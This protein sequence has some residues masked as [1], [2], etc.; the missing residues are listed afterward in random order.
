MTLPEDDDSVFELFIDWLYR[1]RYEMTIPTAQGSGDIYMQPVRLFALADKYDVPSLKSLILSRTFLRIKKERVGKRRMPKL[2]TVAYAYEH[3]AENSPMRK[4][5][6]GSLTCR[7]NYLQR[8]SAH[9]WLR[10][11]PEISADVNVS[12]AKN[13]LKRVNPFDGEMPEEYMDKEQVSDK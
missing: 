12:F 3:T 7:L 9:E 8:A 4:L 10:K 11:H 5:L 13:M 1:Q 6:A 2:S